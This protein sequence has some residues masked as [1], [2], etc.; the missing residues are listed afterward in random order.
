M[1]IQKNAHNIH[2]KTFNKVLMQIKSNDKV[3]IENSAGYKD[4]SANNKVN[5]QTIV[6]TSNKI[7]KIK[8]TFT[9]YI[10]NTQ[11][12]LNK[13]YN[14][15]L[16]KLN[17]LKRVNSESKKLLDALCMQFFNKKVIKES[18]LENTNTNKSIIKYT[19]IID[20]KRAYI[21]NIEEYL[22]GVCANIH[23]KI[24]NNKLNE[25]N[26]ELFNIEKHLLKYI[27]DM[28]DHNKKVKRK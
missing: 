20:N 4:S 13:L 8:I 10:E 11:D 25:A 6:R 1:L 18:I 2:K 17:E 22:D 23:D 26:T 14:D 24:K 28:R 3:P 7:R 19:S 21:G 9:K 16:I 12:P 5:K 27:N 15:N